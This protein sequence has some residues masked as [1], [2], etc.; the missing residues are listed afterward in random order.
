VIVAINYNQKDKPRRNQNFRGKVREM[1]QAEVQRI[2]QEGPGRFPRKTPGE[3]LRNTFQR[4][5][6][7]AIENA[8]KF[9]TTVP[10]RVAF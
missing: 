6:L 2:N 1:L 5:E 8:A 4:G 9:V 10:L 3:S 7:A